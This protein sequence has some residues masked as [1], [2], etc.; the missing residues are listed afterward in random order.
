MKVELLKVMTALKSL[1]KC[2]IQDKLLKNQLFYHKH[3]VIIGQCY[4]FEKLS[5]IYQYRI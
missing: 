5:V 2:G 4:E 3:C 1:K